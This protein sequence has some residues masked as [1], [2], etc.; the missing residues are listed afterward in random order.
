M[1]GGAR[2]LMPKPFTREDLLAAVRAVIG[3]AR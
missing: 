2:H 1:A 3:P